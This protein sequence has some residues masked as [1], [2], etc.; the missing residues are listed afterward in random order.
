MHNNYGCRAV[1]PNDS[2]VGS[3]W[4]GNTTWY[5][6]EWDEDGVK[7]IRLK[8]KSAPE[9]ILRHSDSVITICEAADLN[10]LQDS[11]WTVERTG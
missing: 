8:A 9:L 1:D 6:E 7:G 11:I 10:H 2:E 4:E 5:V 3:I